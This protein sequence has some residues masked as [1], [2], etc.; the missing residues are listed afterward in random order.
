M[1]S[2]EFDTN[3]DI[4]DKTMDFNKFKLYILS[5][6]LTK[7]SYRLERELT[8]CNKVHRNIGSELKPV[9]P[10]EIYKGILKQSD[11]FKRWFNCLAETPPSAYDRAKEIKAKVYECQAK[12]DK[13][14]E[15]FLSNDEK[16]NLRIKKVQQLLEEIA[17]M[18]TLYQTDGENHNLEL[19]I[20]KRE[21]LEDIF[22]K[23]CTDYKENLD[24][25]ITDCE[26]FLATPKIYFHDLGKFCCIV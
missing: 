11:E 26:N 1:S 12:L 24:E 14:R 25:I 13:L 9:K 8:A 2:S 15:I 21:F 22:K 4:T 18:E 19:I 23:H 16:R 20:R 5:G 17:A 7:D 6:K 3:P 10:C